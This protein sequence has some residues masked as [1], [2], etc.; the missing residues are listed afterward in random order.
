[1]QLTLDYG[2]C[3]ES[4]LCLANY[5]AV[6]FGFGDIKGSSIVGD[7]AFKLLD[8]LDAREF[9]PQLSIVC[10]GGALSTREPLKMVSE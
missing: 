2:V 10:W 4:V 8:K 1:M 3:K 7:F 9:L 6:L 5:S